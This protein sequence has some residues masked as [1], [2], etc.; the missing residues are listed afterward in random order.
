MSID[1]TLESLRREVAEL[2]SRFERLLA[3]RREERR[4]ARRDELLDERPIWN[5]TGSTDR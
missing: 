1:D 2:R 3:D 5:T 4:A